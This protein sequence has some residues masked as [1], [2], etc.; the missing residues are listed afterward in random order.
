LIARLS[1]RAVRF[2]EIGQDTDALC[3]LSHTANPALQFH[4]FGAATLD[5]ETPASEAGFDS[6]TEMVKSD[7]RPS[8]VTMQAEALIQAGAYPFPSDLNI[9]AVIFLRSLGA[10]GGQRV[11]LSRLIED[12]HSAGQEIILV[13]DASELWRKVGPDSSPD[14]RDLN[15]ETLTILILPRTTAV[16]VLCFAHLS[17]LGGAE[18]SLLELIDQ[19]ISD[20][21]FFCAVVCPSEGPLPVALREIGAAVLIV[22]LNWWCGPKSAGEATDRQEFPAHDWELHGVLALL[23][24]ATMFRAV[25]PDVVWTQTLVI[26]WGAITARILERPHVWSICE[27]GEKDHNLHFLYPFSSVLKF[28]ENQSEFIFTNSWQLRDF[29]F[30]SIDPSRIDV[31]HRYIKRP[32]VTPLDAEALPWKRPNSFRI[33]VFGSIHS[34]KGQEDIVRA[35]AILREKGQDVEVVLAGDTEPTYLASLG[36]LIRQHHLK[37]IVH[38][39]GFLM[40]PYSVMAAADLVV[41][42]SR[43]EAFGRSVVEAM[44]LGRPVVYTAAGGHLDYMA[45]GETGLAYQPGDV[46]GLV[47]RI[48]TLVEDSDLRRRLAKTA[49]ERAAAMFTPE[50]YGGKVAARLRNYS[51]RDRQTD[52]ASPRDNSFRPFGALGRQ[53]GELVLPTERKLAALQNEMAGVREQLDQARRELT[54]KNLQIEAILG[55]PSWRMMAPVRLLATCVRRLRARLNRR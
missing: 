44:L 23:A 7:N 27:F 48:S 35:A 31:I 53:M 22:P 45:D 47:D 32:D 17:S 33:A 11:F 28:I 36:A 25:N 13:D 1:K 10:T 54:G 38:F 30:P 55:S 12:S 52:S 2:V 51:M 40:D 4:K 5:L 50:R 26:P 14:L 21:W 42:C 39:P 16:G 24:I 3:S 8:I 43:F 29:L 19:L 37:Q 46:D 41:T 34:G 18:R 6:V 20:H 9:L 15:L 49:A